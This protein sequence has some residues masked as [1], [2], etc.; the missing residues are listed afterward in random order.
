MVMP[1][2]DKYQLA[3]FKEKVN[4]SLQPVTVGTA[5]FSPK[6][7]QGLSSPKGTIL[8][9]IPEEV[10]AERIESLMRSNFFLLVLNFL[11]VA[12]VSALLSRFVTYP[13]GRLTEVANEV[14]TRNYNIVI[15]KR[16]PAG[17][18]EVEKIANAFEHMLTNINA[19]HLE[20]VRTRD[21]MTFG[22]VTIVEFRDPETGHHVERLAHYCR[23]L[24]EF[25]R[26]D[27]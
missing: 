16:V 8:V 7:F 15:S 1:Y 26:R 14:S 19:H 12:M 27:R 2:G 9:T 4:G 13:I 25:L 11:V 6:M 3:S 21:A 18:D 20:I 23:E 24:A 22:L 5:R 10:V 17:Y